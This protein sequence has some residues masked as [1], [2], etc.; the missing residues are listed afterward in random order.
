MRGEDERG[1]TPLPHTPMGKQ[2]LIQ[3]RISRIPSD[4]EANFIAASKHE[5]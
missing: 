3:A 4:T 5:K 2:A 1:K